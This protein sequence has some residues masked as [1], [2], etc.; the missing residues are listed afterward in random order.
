[1]VS[2]IHLFVRFLLDSFYICIYFLPYIGEACCFIRNSCFLSVFSILLCFT[3]Q[4]LIVSFYYLNA[5]DEIFV[6]NVYCKFSLL[7]SKHI[8]NFMTTKKITFVSCIYYVWWWLNRNV[9]YLLHIHCIHTQAKSKALCLEYLFQT[10][11]THTGLDILP[12][13]S[14]S[15]I[16]NL[17]I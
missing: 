11:T 12:Q 13:K 3:Y 16:Q 8:F 14:E 7:L 9:V 6:C 5:L 17:D 1:M 15:Q 4:I 2:S 10:Y